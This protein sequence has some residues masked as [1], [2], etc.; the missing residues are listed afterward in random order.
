MRM[1]TECMLIAKRRV[2]SR[3]FLAKSPKR[4]PRGEGHEGE[5]STSG[6]RLLLYMMMI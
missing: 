1:T 6:H 5:G 4:G 3:F 2:A